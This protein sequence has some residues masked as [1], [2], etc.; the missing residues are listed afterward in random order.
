MT[1]SANNVFSIVTRLQALTNH[2]LIKRANLGFT[3]EQPFSWSLINA[4]AVLARMPQDIDDEGYSAERLDQLKIKCASLRHFNRQVG[5][6]DIGMGAIHACLRTEE[7][8]PL[9]A[10][11]QTA[12]DR[13]KVE[14]RSGKCSPA[15]VKVRFVQLY[16]TMYE[17]AQAK[18][19]QTRAL[20]DEVFYICNRSD[21]ELSTAPQS[22]EYE[23]CRVRSTVQAQGGSA[24]GYSEGVVYR[25]EELVDFDQ[26][27]YMI[28]SLLD[29]CVQPTVRATE[30]LQRVLDKSYRITAIAD[31]Q[32]LMKEL[33]QIGTEVG[34]SWAK[35][36][37][38]N[39]AIDAE[40]AKATAED[41]AT[42][43]DLDAQ[44]DAVDLGA[45]IEPE[46]RVVTRTVIKSPERLARE[47]ED[48]RIAQ[49]D[50]TLKAAAAKRAATRA[51]NKAKVS[52]L[53]DLKTIVS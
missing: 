16:T 8:I 20:M 49:V 34:I 15:N 29:R 7:E 44:M 19:R 6:N 25:D 4:A 51:A 52:S 2:S 17:A 3:L 50:A 35:M 12:R 30:E 18:Q 11:K 46:T 32:A 10:I 26:F 9:D 40:L 24:R 37:A 38:E 53:K 27:D 36:D 28:D 22:M 43:E 5:S 1:T 48:Q 14:R 13:V 33:K 47:A 31:A 45:V 23:E 39:A 42:D 21:E 41:E